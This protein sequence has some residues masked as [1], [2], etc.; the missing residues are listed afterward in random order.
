MLRRQ[1]V[2][3]VD[4]S[5]DMFEKLVADWLPLLTDKDESRTITDLLVHCVLE[6]RVP[7]L[8]RK[9]SGKV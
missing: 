8:L 3:S 7:E 5:D 2:A 6:N 9:F 1:E 4:P